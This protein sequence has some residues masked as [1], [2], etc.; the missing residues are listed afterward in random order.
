MTWQQDNHA[1]WQAHK[2]EYPFHAV[3]NRLMPAD[4]T[5][6]PEQLNTHRHGRFIR[7]P[8]GDAVFWAFETEASRDRFLADFGG[9]AWYEIEGEA[10]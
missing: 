9:E 6:R 4:D 1:Y 5:T 8:T 3:H 7:V 2:H 10:P